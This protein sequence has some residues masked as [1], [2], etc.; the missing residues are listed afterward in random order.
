MI[1]KYGEV[2]ENAKLLSYNTYRVNSV[3][4]YLVFPNSVDDL[5]KLLKYL[6]ENNIEYFILGKGSNIILKKDF[7][8]KVFIKLDRLNNVFIDGNFVYAESGK[9]IIPLVMETINSGLKG[10]E[11]ATGI[12]G[13]IGG[14]IYNN[15]GAYND[16]IFNYVKE[17]TILD[18]SNRVRVLNKEDIDYSYRNTSFKSKKIVILSCKLELKKGVYSDSISLIEDRKK[19]RFESQPLEYP[20]AGSVFRN[21]TDDFAGRL[22]EELGLKGYNKNGVYISKKHANFIINK[23]N[24]TGLDI[25]ELIDLIKLKVKE[26]YNID[27]ILEQ[28]IIE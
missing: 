9:E 19:R 16:C 14:C 23:E 2:I 18:D 1:N 12:P 15:A 11:W 26:K 28:E 3:V 5:I 22:I 17:V 6:K 7:Y 8:D 20:S 4:K 21:P 13:T 27:L 25:V 24:G 10:L